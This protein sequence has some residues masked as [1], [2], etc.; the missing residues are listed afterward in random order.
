MNENASNDLTGALP[1]EM[2]QDFLAWL[3]S[4]W[5][6]HRHPLAPLEAVL[7]CDLAKQALP[8]WV[9][10]SIVEVYREALDGGLWAKPGRTNNP[11]AAMLAVWRDFCRFDAVRRI[12]NIVAPKPRRSEPASAPAQAVNQNADDLFGKYGKEPWV[13]GSRWADTFEDASAL[14]E[15]T[16]AEGGADTIRRSYKKFLR[17]H[18]KDSWESEMFLPLSAT[19][20]GMRIS[21][22]TH[23]G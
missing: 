9:V 22:K 15:G 18:E 20:L 2:L 16:D 23:Q 10:K 8:E 17:G 1:P 3:Q 6:E 4:D 21:S 11:R 14:L 19:A 12:R 5:E 7:M 13:L